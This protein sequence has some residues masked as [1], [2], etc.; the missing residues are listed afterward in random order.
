MFPREKKS[1]KEVSKEAIDLIIRILQERED[2]LCSLRYRVNDILIGRPVTSNFL[3]SMDRRNINSYYV[4]PNDAVEIKAHPFFRGVQ[5]DQLH[6]TPPPM[7]PRV[8]GWEDTRYFKDWKS[9]GPADELLTESE[10][11]ESDEKSDETPNESNTEASSPAQNQ[12]LLEQPVSD[13]DAIN[14]VQVDSQKKPATGKRKA[15]KRPRDKVL[16]DKRVGKTALEIRKKSAFLGYT[17]RRPKGPALAL[18]QDRGRQRF[19]RD[20]MMELYAL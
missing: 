10:N 15:R 6:L 20:Q 17:Y 4:F 5:W 2:R 13:I 9:S 7:I 1:D 19:G 14:P 11:E 18:S 8:R 3:Y 16:R 12:P